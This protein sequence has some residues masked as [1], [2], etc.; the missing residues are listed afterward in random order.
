MV[1]DAPGPVDRPAV[2]ARGVPPQDRAGW[3]P[4]GRVAQVQGRLRHQYPLLRRRGRDAPSLTV[5]VCSARAIAAVTGLTATTASKYACS[6]PGSR[7]Y[8]SM[9]SADTRTP[10]SA[11]YT[12]AI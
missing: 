6:T 12:A 7:T 8:R 10:C 3:D 1:R 9:S 2:R 4:L 5:S 11:A